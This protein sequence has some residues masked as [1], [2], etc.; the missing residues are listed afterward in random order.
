MK[1]VSENSVCY[2]VQIERTLP[3]ILTV[4]SIRAHLWNMLPS[5]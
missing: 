1:T 5:F 2:C 3:N 4:G